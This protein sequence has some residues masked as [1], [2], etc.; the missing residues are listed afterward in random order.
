MALSIVKRPS[1]M[2]VAFANAAAKEIKTKKVDHSRA[3]VAPELS[4]VTRRI[5]LTDTNIGMVQERSG[6]W[7]K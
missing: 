3:T 2:A 4:W 6:M 1:N 7:L 5:A